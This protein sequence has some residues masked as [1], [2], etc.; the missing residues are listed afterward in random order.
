M[1]MHDNAGEPGVRESRLLEGSAHPP[2]GSECDG[3]WDGAW[4]LIPAY[5]E[6]RT[7]RALAQAALVL[8]PRVIVVDDGS[9][10]GS[11][12]QLR[13]LKLTLLRHR[14][15]RGKAASLRSGFEAALREGALCVVTLDGDGQHDPGDASELLAVWRG[16]PNR[17]VIGARLHDRAQFPLARY[18]ANRFACFWISWAAGHPIADSQSGFRVYPAAAMAAALD[19]GVR[20]DRFTFESEVLI[21][22][23]DRG[24]LTLAVAIPGRYP[25]NARHSHFRPVVDILK[26]V[27]MVAGRLLR[28]GLYPRGL[29]RSRGTAPVLRRDRGAD[30]HACP[31]SLDQAGARKL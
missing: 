7:L 9:S 4:L 11:A 26:I 30:V 1:A 15:N 17:I 20:G 29:W 5:N 2:P 23:A 22:A 12:E 6:E 13:G 31:A 25:E 3:A 8:C 16:E 28:K 21:E 19:G 18:L 27:A 10:D 14:E 24:V